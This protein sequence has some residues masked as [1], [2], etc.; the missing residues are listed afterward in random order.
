MPEIYLN[1]LSQVKFFDILKPLLVG[2][3]NGIL[4]IKGKDN[5]EVYLENGNIVHAKTDQSLGEDAFITIMGWRTGRC[6]FEPDIFPQERTIPIPSEQL[7][8]N[9]SYRKQEWEKIRKIIP[10]PHAIFRL[11]L[12]NQSEDKNIRSDQWK[13]LALTNGVRTV[14]EITN[15]LAWDEFKT[16]KVI[17]QLVQAGLLEKSEDRKPAGRKWVGEDFFPL[18]EFE[19]K[20]VMGPV[21]QFLIDDKLDELGEAR[22]SFPRDQAASFIEVLAGEIHHDQKRKEFVRALEKFLPSEK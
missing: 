4:V 2:K 16:S 18:V 12:Q 14:S 13:V 17:Y 6:T 15:T 21:A 20:K 19:L 11:S 9:W 3:K 5:G 8:L 22:D 7:L 10:S 1:E